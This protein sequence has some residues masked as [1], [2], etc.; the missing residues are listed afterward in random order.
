MAGKRSSDK[1]KKLILIGLGVA[2]AGVVFYQFFLA[3]PSPRPARNSAA[4]NSNAGVNRQAPAPIQTAT[5]QKVSTARDS[6]PAGQAAILQELL[7]DQT[8]LDLSS[9]SREAAPAKAGPRGSIF[10][11]YVKPP[12][13]P[14]PKPIA[15]IAIKSIQP[16]TAVAG[17]PRKFSLKVFAENMPPDATIFWN[18]FVH[19]S[20]RTGQNELTTEVQPSEYTSGRSINVEVRSTSDPTKF[21]DPLVFV[22]QATPEPPLRYIARLGNMNQPDANFGVFELTATKEIKRMKRGE[23]IAG[24]WRIDAINAESVDLTHTQYDIK[25]RVMLQEKP[26]R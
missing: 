7:A 16:Q 17:T 13:P 24:V 10:G 21:S 18:G 15:P 9:F 19:P 4:R 5:P 2:L 12:E 11:Y 1:T 20:S 3:G 23:T 22:V 26:K 25:R 8:P 6:S 14:K